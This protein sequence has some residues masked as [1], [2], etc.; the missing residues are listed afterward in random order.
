MNDLLIKVR[1]W[2]KPLELMD[3]SLII[4]FVITLW[5]L[6]IWVI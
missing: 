4:L 1:E 5:F 6:L 2:L 3:L